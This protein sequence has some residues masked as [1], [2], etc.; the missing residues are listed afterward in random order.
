M[1][2][3]AVSLAGGLRVRELEAADGSAVSGVFAAAADYFV[4]VTGGPALDGDVQSLFY[5]APEGVSPD[6]KV[7]LVAEV[8]GEVIAVVD[9]VPGHPAPDAVA[10]GLFLLTPAAR[11]RGVGS[12]IAR[13]LLDAARDRGFRRITATTAAGWAPGTGFLTRLGFDLDDTAAAA[14]SGNRVVAAAE[15]PLVVAVLEMTDDR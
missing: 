13:A 14:G 8:D 3:A 15:R 6:A 4:A 10:V 5:A 1:T 9:V 12:R 2:F 11:G 7:L